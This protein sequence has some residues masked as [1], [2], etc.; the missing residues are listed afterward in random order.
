MID[1]DSKVP[2]GKVRLIPVPGYYIPGVPDVVQDVSP[3]RAE[4]LLAYT[5]RA[6]VVDE[7]A[8]SGP[9]TVVKATKTTE[10]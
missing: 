6:F 7:P 3:K 8:P 1:M 5:P 10:E 4:E 2:K 9:I